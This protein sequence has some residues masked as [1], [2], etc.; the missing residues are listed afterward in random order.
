MSIRKPTE[1]VY[2]ES[3][4]AQLKCKVYK[5]QYIFW[6]KVLADI[7]NDSSTSI[8]KIYTL[9]ITKNL[10]HIRHCQKLHKDFDTAKLCHNYHQNEFNSKIKQSFINKTVVERNSIF[11]D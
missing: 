6:N 1:I 11:N 3:G 8:A 10:Q 5:R 4:L 2:I 9:A 7:E